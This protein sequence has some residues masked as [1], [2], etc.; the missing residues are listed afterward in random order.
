MNP[1]R[2]KGPINYAALGVWLAIGAGIG[3][4]IGA[5]TGQMGVWVGVGAGVGTALGAVF[6]L[7]R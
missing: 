7:K 2:G 5:A 6:T 1:E 3:T 4:A